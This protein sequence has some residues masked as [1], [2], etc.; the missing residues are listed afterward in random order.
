MKI[1]QQMNIPEEQFQLIVKYIDADL[2]ADEQPL[3]N[4]LMLSSEAFRKELIQ[5]ELII[6]SIKA[7]GHAENVKRVKNIIKRYDLQERE[8]KRKKRR[9]P[10]RIG[11]AASVSLILIFAYLGI[12]HQAADSREA[13]Y[14]AYF[15]VYPVSSTFRNDSQ[16]SEGLALY[17]QKEY[18]AA[19]PLLQKEAELSKDNQ[20]A[21]IYLANA[22]LMTDQFE[23]AEEVLQ[24]LHISEHKNL[25]D[26]NIM[27]FLGMAQLRLNKQEEAALQ[28]RKLVNTEGYY[29][30]DAKVILEKME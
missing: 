23:M 20:Q 28:F 1:N 22:Y 18:E 10:I 3:F 11:I 26:Q 5:V 6:S 29:S 2:A 15:E 4:E 12:N 27:W 7:I 17:Q 14:Q 21:A 25:S 19:I 8:K 30:E 13:I 9:L 16:L 24:G